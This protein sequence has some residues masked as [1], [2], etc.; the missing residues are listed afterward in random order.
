[1]TKLF[2]AGATGAVGKQV[3]HIL[4]SEDVDFIAHLRPRPGREEH[5]LVKSA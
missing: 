2:I 3:V 5:E 4:K 1:M